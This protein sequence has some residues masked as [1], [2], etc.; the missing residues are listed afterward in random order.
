MVLDQ[1]ISILEIQNWARS[2]HKQV[3]TLPVAIK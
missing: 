2:R 1:W 3:K